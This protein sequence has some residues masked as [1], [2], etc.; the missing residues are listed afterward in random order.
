MGKT[1]THKKWKKSH[2]K[3]ISSPMRK[4]IGRKSSEKRLD[5]D[6]I[7]VADQHRQRQHF[8]I[9]TKPSNRNEKILD[10]IDKENVQV[11]CNSSAVFKTLIPQNKFKSRA[12][13]YSNNSHPYSSTMTKGK[14][15]SNSKS[16]ISRPVYKHLLRLTPNNIRK[17]RNFEHDYTATDG[18][19]NHDRNAE[20]PI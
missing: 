3:P 14:R 13:V 15:K 9:T 6:N 7:A 17:Q 10:D 20:T 8:P 5:F 18:T 19:M 11:H 1:A 2:K 4:V 12:M 16:S